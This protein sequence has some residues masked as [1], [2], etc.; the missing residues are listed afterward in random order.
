MAKHIITPESFDGFIQTEN[1]LVISLKAFQKAMRTFDI[2]PED[3][4]VFD[5]KMDE[6]DAAISDLEHWLKNATPAQEFIEDI[7]DMAGR[8]T[9]AA[10]AIAAGIVD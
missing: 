8:A 6:L 4:E 10:E 3:Q 5:D 2:T 7:F 9:A 1:Q